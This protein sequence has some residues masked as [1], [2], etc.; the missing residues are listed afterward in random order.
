MPGYS[1][2][3]TDDQV[4]ALIKYV[5]ADF[6]DRPAWQKVDREIRRVRKSFAEMH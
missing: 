6:T 3:L 1:G 2:A 4:A 5:R